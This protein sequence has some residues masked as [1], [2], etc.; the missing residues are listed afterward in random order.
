MIKSRRVYV[1]KGLTRAAALAKARAKSR[2]D[3]RC[4]TYSARTG[5]ATLT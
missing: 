5:W 1:G 3:Y 4:F 2:G